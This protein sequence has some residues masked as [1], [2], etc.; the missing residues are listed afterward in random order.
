MSTFVAKKNNNE[1]LF[2]IFVSTSKLSFPGGGIAA[3]GT[4]DKNIIDIIG[5]MKFQTIGFD[6]INQLRHVKYFKDLDGLREHAKKHGKIL[7]RKFDI[8][9]KAL[10]L[11]PPD[12]FEWTRP[13]GGYFVTV[14]INGLAKEIIERCKWC[15]VVLTESGSTHPYHYDE[16]NSFIRIAPSFINDDELEIAMRVFVLS[17]SIEFLKKE[18]GK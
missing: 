8:V 3:I 11:L 5:Q 9:T 16:T 12:V 6:K 7:Q 15:G 13:S 18:Q 4:S 2:Y 10:S 1:D 17:A 14:R